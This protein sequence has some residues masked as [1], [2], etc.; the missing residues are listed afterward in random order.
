MVVWEGFAG[1]GTILN[2]VWMRFWTC[3]KIALKR[4]LELCPALAKPFWQDLFRCVGLENMGTAPPA[5]ALLE[6]ICPG[7][8]VELAGHVSQS[9]VDTFGNLGICFWRGLRYQP[10]GCA[11]EGH[12]WNI[13]SRTFQ[14]DFLERVLHEILIRSYHHLCLGA[15]IAPAVWSRALQAHGIAE[16]IAHI[17][18]HR[19]ISCTLQGLAKM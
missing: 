5:R 16:R 1:Q 15:L 4:Y 9:V 14:K 12:S 13:S 19:C 11:W 17:A 10:G 18:Q 7:L 3:S 2:D 6:S 8:V